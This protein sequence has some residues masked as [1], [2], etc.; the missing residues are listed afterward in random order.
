VNG[1][2]AGDLAQASLASSTRF[3]DLEA[4]VNHAIGSRGNCR[5][6]ADPITIHQI[7]SLNVMKTS[8]FPVIQTLM[9]SSLLFGTERQAQIL[10]LIGEHGSVNVANLVA[11]FSISPATARRDLDEMAAN[12]Q[13][14]RTHGGAVA[15]S[16]RQTDP[17]FAARQ[18]LHIEEKSRIGRICAGLIGSDETIFLDAGTTVLTVA[19]H[20]QPPG[21]ALIVTNSAPLPLGLPAALRAQIY[22]IGGEFRAANLSHVPMSGRMQS[23]RSQPSA[24]R[25]Q[26]SA[27]AASIRSGESSPPRASPRPRFSARRSCVRTA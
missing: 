18:A 19:R 8:C 1:A 4:A 12:G 13:L 17:A 20:I 27:A 25:P 7:Q 3:I 5:K 11:R 26:S 10:A 22:V 15:R 24:F 2:R 14:R 6:Q 16:E 23:R 21:P 9:K